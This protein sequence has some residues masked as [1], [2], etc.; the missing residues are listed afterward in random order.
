MSLSLVSPP[1]HEPVTLS[2]LKQH[3]RLSGNDDDVSLV[4]L[5]MAA[6]HALEARAGIAFLQQQWIYHPPRCH[7]DIILPITPVASIDLVQWNKN[8]A[9]IPLVRDVDYIETTGQFGRIQIN[10]SKNIYSDFKN[11]EIRFTAG[12]LEESQIPPE[13]RHSIRLLTA[14]FYENR[15]SAAEQRVFSIPRSIDALIA[16]YRRISV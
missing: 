4:G 7:G 11:L 16:P 2:D 13:L 8:D 1:S 5:A 15:E 6:R 9:S 12:Y 3:L 10:N 14:H